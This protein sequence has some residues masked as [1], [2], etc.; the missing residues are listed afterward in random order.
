MVK[1]DQLKQAHILTQQSVS[2]ALPVFLPENVIPSADAGRLSPVLICV[3][4][5]WA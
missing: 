3:R 1:T 5:S 2:C 4:G